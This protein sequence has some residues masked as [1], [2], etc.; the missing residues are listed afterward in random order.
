M[1]FPKRRVGSPKDVWEARMLN[2]EK[3][4]ADVG[5][6]GEMIGRKKEWHE[7]VRELIG[8]ICETGV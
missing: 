7:E 3:M 5:T 6:L 1:R 4:M 8:V 2:G